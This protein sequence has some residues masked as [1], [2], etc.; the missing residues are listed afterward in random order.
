MYKISKHFFLSLLILSIYSCSSL[1]KPEKAENPKVLLYVFNQTKAEITGNA[2]GFDGFELLSAFMG[3]SGGSMSLS[4]E[5]KIECVEMVE[6]TLDED[7]IDGS[8]YTGYF[9]IYRVTILDQ[10]YYS[11]L[12]L[13]EFDSGRAE[14]KLEAVETSLSE[15]KSWLY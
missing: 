2:F 12:S 11:L 6:W 3:G 13:T 5:E 7:L 8:D 4:D 14:W 9:V 15:I 1:L 10:T